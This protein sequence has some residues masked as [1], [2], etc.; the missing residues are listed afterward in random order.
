MWSYY[1]IIFNVICIS[2]S[3]TLLHQKFTKA[4]V[5]LSLDTGYDTFVLNLTIKFLLVQL[6]CNKILTLGKLCQQTGE[7]RLILI[8]CR[9]VLFSV[10]IYFYKT[11]LVEITLMLQSVYKT[12]N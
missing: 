12:G 8:T 5:S 7:I 6:G 1:E 4:S 3:I 2:L 9:I 10:L 11:M